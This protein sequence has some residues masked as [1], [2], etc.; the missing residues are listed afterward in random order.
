MLRGVF[1]GVCALL[2]SGCAEEPP[3]P[4]TADLV[5]EGHAE[6]RKVCSPCHGLNGEGT[7]LLGKDLRAN[8][9]VNDRTDDE[10]VTFIIEGRSSVHPEN[11]RGIEMPPRG[12]NPSLTDDQIRKIVAY[13]RSLN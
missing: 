10:L 11:T 1:V 6:Y 2:L 3:A 9:F 5:A 12:G 8:A 7:R 13:M 4:V